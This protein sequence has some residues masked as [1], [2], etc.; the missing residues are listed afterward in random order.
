VDYSE[1]FKSKMIQRMCGP[2]A[3]SANDLAQ[4]VGV[5]QTTLSRWLRNARTVGGMP[6]P[7]KPRPEV[8]NRSPRR[9]EDWTPEE[10]LQAVLEASKLSDAE[11]GEF[12]RREGLHEAVLAEWR[13]SAFGALSGPAKAASN[14]KEQRRIR[15]LEK[16]LRRKDK[17]LAEAAALLVLA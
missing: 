9:P 13:V 10:K 17:A 11:L 15:E 3:R 6:K 4:E 5:P 12:L 2:S 8:Q 14:A 1:A 7:R 16:E